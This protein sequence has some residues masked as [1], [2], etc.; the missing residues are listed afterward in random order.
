M[1]SGPGVIVPV[2]IDTNTLVPSLF[3]ETRIF[4]YILSGNLALIW[5]DFIYQE[6]AEISERLFYKVY[7]KATHAND[8]DKVFRILELIFI[9]ENKVNDMPFD[10]PRVSRDREDDPFLF[11]AGEGEAEYIISQD[12]PHML[13]LNNFRGIPIGTPAQFFEWAKENRPM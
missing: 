2:V 13:R 5:N 3:R 8:L 10:W 9:P 7:Y 6:V 1:S 12:K 4:D 11:A